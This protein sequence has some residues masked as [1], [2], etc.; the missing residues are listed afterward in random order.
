MFAGC[1]P[2]K[3]MC[4]DIFT[5]TCYS[6]DFWPN[7][8]NF[9]KLSSAIH[10]LQPGMTNAFQLPSNLS[11]LQ[12][13]PRI[14]EV[15]HRQ[16]AFFDLATDATYSTLVA[17]NATSFTPVATNTT[18]STHV[19]KCN[20]L[21][22]CSHKYNN[23][24]KATNITSSTHAAKNATSSTHAATNTTYFTHVASNSTSFILVRTANLNP[25]PQVCCF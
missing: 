13:K 12:F 11:L 9:S 1:S 16:T 4:C 3:E 25:G 21:H 2:G 22:T 17:I 20:F 7:T 5:V 23:L 10:K 15:G 14:V 6:C 19:A 24:H 18:S 8:S